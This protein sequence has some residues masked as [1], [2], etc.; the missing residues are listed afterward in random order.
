MADLLQIYNLTLLR[1]GHSKR[2]PSLPST[3]VEA[4]LCDAVYNFCREFVL[5]DFPWRF[6]KQR[7]ALV[8]LEGTPPDNWLYQYA[9]PTDCL[10]ARYIE[11]PGSRNPRTDDK[12]NYEIAN[13]AP[14]TVGETTTWVDAIY[15][16]QPEATLVYT[17]DIADPARFDAHFVSSLAWLMGS[18][19]IGPLKGKPELQPQL[20]QLYQRTVR[21]AAAA[22]MSE[23]RE[24]TPESEFLGARNG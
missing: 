17:Q 7:A 12:I 8:A 24:S 10:R 14:I 11:M 21:D 9:K 6:A 2:I 19:L 16:D 13:S 15:T 18:E 3:S 1:V 20:Y 22:S 5:R 23:G 4:E